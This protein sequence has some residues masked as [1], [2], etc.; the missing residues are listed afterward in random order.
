MRRDQRAGNGLVYEGHGKEFVH[1]VHLWFG[2]RALM[3]S[4]YQAEPT[5]I[6]HAFTK[7]DPV[8]ATLF[9]R[10]VDHVPLLRPEVL[11]LPFNALGQIYWG[12]ITIQNEGRKGWIMFEA[13]VSRRHW[14]KW[15]EE[16][17][18]GRVLTPSEIQARI[19]R[20]LHGR[21]P[22]AAVQNDFFDLAG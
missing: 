1:L 3:R 10:S 4:R 13:E 11:P 9:V 5:K 2:E 19:S 21:D 18:A 6:T 17:A 14:N 20:E 16:L 22:N 12:T 15:R 8:K 7:A